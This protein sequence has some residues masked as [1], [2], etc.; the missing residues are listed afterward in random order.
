MA[1]EG[2]FRAKGFV[3]RRLGFDTGDI[4][5]LLPNEL[6]D[7]PV[8]IIDSLKGFVEPVCIGCCC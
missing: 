3:D 2:E 8:G 1:A 5:V 6:L 4:G 7:A